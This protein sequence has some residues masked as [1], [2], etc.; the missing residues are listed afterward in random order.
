MNEKQI[1][2]CDQ[3]WRASCWQGIFMCDD[4]TNAG[5]A[6]APIAQL[7]RLALENECYWK[8]DE[9]LRTEK[10]HD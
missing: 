10:P 6:K 5:V 1:T 3:C 4:A 8:T 7:R 9:E 2:V